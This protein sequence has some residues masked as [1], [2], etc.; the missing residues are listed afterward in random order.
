MLDLQARVHFEEIEVAVLVD[1]ELDRAGAL[2]V[3]RLGQR[4]RLLAHGAPRLLVEERR[5]RLLDDL[6][7]AALD[8]AFAL[9]EI[10]RV[11][12]RV[13]QHLDLDMARVDDE[14]LDEHAVVAERALGLRSGALEAVAQLGFVPGDAHALAAA[15]GR[16]LDHHGIADLGRR[17]FRRASAS[18]MTP[19]KPG[20]VLTLAALANFFEFD[21]VAHR[22]DGLGL[23][24]DEDDAL[25]FQRRAEGGAFGQEAVA[26]MH[27]LARRSALQASMIFSGDEIALRGR[28][29]A[30]MHRLVGHLDMHGLAIGVGIDRD[31]RDA[32]LPRRLDDAAGDLAAIGDQD[33]LEHRRAISLGASLLWACDRASQGARHCYHPGRKRVANGTVPGDIARVNQRGNR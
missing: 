14:F 13:G 4:H 25:R 9:A 2:V 20:T 17:S 33:F 3:D 32:H 24:A 6:L 19:R 23:G 18:S 29:R 10:D 15:A 31:G 21:L 11:A 12:M 30:D 7:V 22:L 26:G 16:G 5:R 1:D 8:R 27:G 28:R